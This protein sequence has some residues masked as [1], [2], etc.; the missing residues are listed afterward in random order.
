[1]P[2]CVSKSRA[3]ASLVM[4]SASFVLS[5]ASLS[6]WP[7][8]VSPAATFQQQLVAGANIRSITALTFPCCKQ[9]RRPLR[10]ER[11]SAPENYL[12][13]HFRLQSHNAQGLGAWLEMDAPLILCGLSLPFTQWYPNPRL[14]STKSPVF[15]CLP[16]SSCPSLFIPPCDSPSGSLYYV[17]AVC[18]PFLY[19]CYWLQATHPAITVLWLHQCIQRRLRIVKLHCLLPLCYFKNQLPIK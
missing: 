18:F 9:T 16:P 8:P 4:Q 17:Y 13:C 5:E 2:L 7:N 1:M 12:S 15:L 6:I 3:Y 11:S 19:L 14:L 10:V